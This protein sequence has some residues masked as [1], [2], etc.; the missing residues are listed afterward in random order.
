MISTPCSHSHS[1]T[2]LKNNDWYAQGAP[3]KLD[4][5][6]IEQAD[7]VFIRLND[8]HAE[9]SLLAA[10][11]ALAKGVPTHL[12]VP[13]RTHLPWF[14]RNAEL[15]YPGQVTIV[16]TDPQIAPDTEP[17]DPK[18]YQAQKHDTFIG[19]LMSGLSKEQYKDGRNHLL[20]IHHTLQREFD[21]QEN[22]CE[23]INVGSNDS[24]GTPK[25][26]LVVDMEAIKGSRNCVFYQYDNTSRPS[27]MWV[28]LGAALALDKPCTLMAPN[29]DGVPPSIKEGLPNLKVVQYGT[30]ENFKR[31]LADNAEV[32]R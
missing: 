9:D 6:L 1:R 18:V 12:T 26:A 21:S 17:V 30:H 2:K 5:N 23:G 15:S 13:D 27:G 31:L 29:L 4:P 7:E 11:M 20:N 3:K 24:F 19:C 14:M 25:E 8:P 32:L 22:F 28:E 16:E 10:G